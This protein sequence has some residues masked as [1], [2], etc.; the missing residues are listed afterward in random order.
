MKKLVPFFLILLII[1]ACDTK[2]DQEEQQEEVV[3]P[4][5]DLPLS[6]KLQKVEFEGVEVEVLKVDPLQYF[7]M[8]ADVQPGNMEFLGNTITESYGKIAEQ[9]DAEHAP[10][11]AKVMSVY[12]SFGDV[13]EL[14]IAMQIVSEQSEPRVTN[15]V[16]Q[17]GTTDGGYAVK[18]VHK[19]SY[20]NL[21]ETHNKVKKF[22]EQKNLQILGYPYEIY[23]TGPTQQQDTTNWITEIYYP[24]NE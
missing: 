15:G 2:P 1:A 13:I 5:V 19:G 9:I 20:K 10:D 6:D 14:V 8:Q 16:F 3:T 18:G 12:Q 22:I 17:Y 24:V 23:V 21:L 11:T 4:E 7:G